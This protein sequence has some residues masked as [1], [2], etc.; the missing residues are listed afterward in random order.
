MKK[1]ILLASAFVLMCASVG[2]AGSGEPAEVIN[3][4]DSVVVEEVD[5]LVPDTIIVDSVVC[6]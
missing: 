1:L 4:S 2:C 5:T 6:E 3:D